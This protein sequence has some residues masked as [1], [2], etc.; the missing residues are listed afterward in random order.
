MLRQGYRRHLPKCYYNNSNEPDSVA[1]LLWNVPAGSSSYSLQLPTGSRGNVCV[2]AL[3]FCG[4]RQL[5]LSQRGVAEVESRPPQALRCSPTVVPSCRCSAQWGCWG[6]WGPSRQAHVPLWVCSAGVYR[7]RGGVGE[8]VSDWRGWEW[9]FETLKCNS[10]IWRVSSTYMCWNSS[11]DYGLKDSN[12]WT[13]FRIS[14]HTSQSF[15]CFSMWLELTSS[16]LDIIWPS[17]LGWFECRFLENE[18]YLSIWTQGL[19]WGVNW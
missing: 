6:E 16:S 12:Y 9:L 18:K 4:S 11:C 1:V 14:K 19:W 3:L 7:S 17:V 10:A 8:R 15:L 13:Y 5:S 2:V